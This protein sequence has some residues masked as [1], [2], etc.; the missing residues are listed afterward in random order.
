MLDTEVRADAN[1]W[2]NPRAVSIETWDNGDPDRVPW[3]P[4]QIT[5]MVRL[6]RWLSDTHSIPLR[7]CPAWDAPGV[8]YHSQYA[9]WSPVVK[10]CPGLARRPQVPTVIAAARSATP[11]EDDMAFTATDSRQ[12]TWL[13]AGVFRRPI[14]WDQANALTQLAQPV[15]YQGAIDDTVLGAYQLFAGADASAIAAEV[16]ANLTPAAIAAAI[17]GGLAGQVVDELHRRTAD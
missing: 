3:N 10:T 11:P 4:A 7:P 8:G 13:I 6:L 14:S 1:Y 9:Q 12:Q 5:A 17:P 15:A 16:L 2:A